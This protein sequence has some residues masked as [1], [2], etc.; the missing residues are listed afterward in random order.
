MKIYLSFGLLLAVRFLSQAQDS[1]TN[2]DFESA[3]LPSVP[4]GQLGGYQ[5]I[6]AALPGWAGYLGSIPQTEVRH[7]NPSTGP[8]AIEVY[9]PEWTAPLVIEGRFSVA[10]VP[11]SV[12]P[13][14]GE[15]LPASLSQTGLVP[16]TANSLFFKMV[17]DTH[18]STSEKRY[19]VYLGSEELSLSPV[20]EMPDFTLMGADVSHFAGSEVELRF[21]AFWISVPNFLILDSISFSSEPVPE[22][23]IV[24]LLMVGGIGGQIVLRRLKRFR[25]GQT[26][27]P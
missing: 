7:N 21:T 5:P 19:A 20:L 1:F 27:L 6:Q 10:L 13:N 4:I 26:G 25:K 15:S 22:P 9:G 18:V 8:G 24:V 14:L 3:N 2:L 23:G 17:T 11:G 12:P 16:E